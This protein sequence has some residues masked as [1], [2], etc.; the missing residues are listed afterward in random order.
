MSEA[1]KR[2]EAEL[3]HYYDFPDWEDCIG[4]WNTAC[5]LIGIRRCLWVLRIDFNYPDGLENLHPS[6]FKRVLSALRIRYHEL[7]KAGKI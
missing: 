6:K 4:R 2:T 3:E 7:K 1:F 5:D